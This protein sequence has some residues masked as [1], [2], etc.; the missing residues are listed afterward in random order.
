MTVLTRTT[1][2]GST[3]HNFPP[4]VSVAPVDYDSIDSLTAALRGQDAV[5][6][7]LGAAA[8]AKQ[9]LL[10]NAAAQAGVKRFIPSDFGSDTLHPKSAALPVYAD[11]VTVQKAL[12]DK[13][14]QQGPD[15]SG[16]TYTIV[17]CGPFLDWGLTVPF[18]LDQRSQQS[19]QSNPG[20]MIGL[21]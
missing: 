19:N 13:A 10:V 17:L 3:T 2:S 20:L 4:S 12:R 9:L 18:L 21:N 1:G 14:A 16:L 6:S 11:K 7:T 8:L 5:V 15:G